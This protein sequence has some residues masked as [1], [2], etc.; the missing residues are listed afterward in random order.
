[1]A[2]FGTPSPEAIEAFEKA[3]REDPGLIKRLMES[4]LELDLMRMPDDDA[5][6]LTTEELLR[7]LEEEQ[8]LE[9]NV[10]DSDVDKYILIGGGQAVRV[11]DFEQ[12]A[13]QEET[14]S[15]R[16][17]GFDITAARKAQ[18]RAMLESQRKAL[19]NPK[20]NVTKER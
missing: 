11:V 13:N 10:I 17:E 2:E 20:L 4:A 8:P 18:K 9:G 5:P 16:A 14:S 15:S 19:A 3:R 1:M 7:G 12:L 6:G